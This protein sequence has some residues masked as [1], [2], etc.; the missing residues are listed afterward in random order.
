MSWNPKRFEKIISQTVDH[1]HVFGT[2]VCIHTPD[3]SWTGALGNLTE[4]SP[5]FIASTTKLYITALILHMR[6]NHQ[7]QLD[8]TIAT[9][10]PAEVMN[11]LHIYKGHDYSADITLR[12]LLS[13]TSGLPDYFEQKRAHGQSLMSAITAGKDQS[14][15]FDEAVQASKAMKPNFKPGQQGKAHYSDTNFQLLGR[16][17]EII[18][19]KKLADVFQQY[20]FEPLHLQQTY[21][22]EDVEDP[23]PTHLYYKKQ[24]LLIPKAMASFGADGGIVSTAAETMIFLKAFFGGSLFPKEYLEALQAWNRIFFPL[25]YGVGIARFKWPRIFSPFQPVPELIGHSGLSGAFAFYCP[26]KEVYLTGTV[27]QIHPPSLSFK[28]MIKLLNAI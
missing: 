6:A 1:P 19:G 2:V 22:Y 16:V 5:Y 15:S 28:L 18:S 14:W 21:L 10:L 4:N 11:R 27:N 3:G 25:Q 7:L 12:H 26:A 20:I 17:I 8:D 24:P 13:Q 9:Y 23:R